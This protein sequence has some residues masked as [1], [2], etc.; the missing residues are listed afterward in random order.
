MQC[1]TKEGLLVCADKRHTESLGRWRDDH[2]KLARLDDHWMFSLA[3][4]VALGGSGMEPILGFRSGLA[5]RADFA[6][7]NGIANYL[8]ENPPPADGVKVLRYTDDPFAP[9]RRRIDYVGKLLDATRDSFRRY[10]LTDPPERGQLFSANRHLVMILLCGKNTDGGVFSMVAMLSLRRD[11]SHG[12][13]SPRAEWTS[14]VDLELRPAAIGDTSVFSSVMTR[15]TTLS[16]DAS[17]APFQDWL[18]AAKPDVSTPE[19]LI[20][21][22]CDRSTL[23]SSSVA[24][25]GFKKVCE[26]THAQD[27]SGQT[28]SQCDWVVLPSQTSTAG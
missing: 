17:L 15:K 7:A 10:M 8:V 14:V 13:A 16:G 19:C 26:L 9:L 6:F 1:P 21:S 24:L 27:P 3:G 20:G 2:Y 4:T 12:F 5:P 18:A 28:G 11:G 23:L 22:E 25:A